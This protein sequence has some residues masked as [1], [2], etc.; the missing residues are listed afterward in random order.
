MALCLH[1]IHEWVIM[2]RQSSSYT[3][4]HTHTHTYTR[5]RVLWQSATEFR[6]GKQTKESVIMAF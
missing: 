4:T 5:A 3:H 6:N 1:L 2:Q